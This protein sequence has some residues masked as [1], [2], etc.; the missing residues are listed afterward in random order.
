MAIKEN[1][2][3]VDL[4][5]MHLESRMRFLEDPYG[6]LHSSPHETPLRIRMETPHTAPY[7]TTYEA[8]HEAPH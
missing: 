8:T 2:I 7:E 1:P 6:D 4:T 5:D 3:L